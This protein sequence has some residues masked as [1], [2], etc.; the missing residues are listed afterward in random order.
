MVVA[1]VV[2]AVVVEETTDNESVCVTVCSVLVVSWVVDA[3]ARSKL[4]EL[5]AL[6]VDVTFSMVDC[7]SVATIPIRSPSVV[8]VPAFSDAPCPSLTSII[9]SVVVAFV[10]VVPS[11]MNPTMALIS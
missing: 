7:I 4:V 10:V 1:A 9:N 3:A 6:F 2:D 11:A 5:V 8:D